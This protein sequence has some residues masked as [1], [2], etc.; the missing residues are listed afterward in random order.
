[1]SLTQIIKQHDFSDVSNVAIPYNILSESYGHDLAVK[2]LQLEHEAFELGEKR[3]RLNLE[4]QIANG[5]GADNSAAKPLL[6]SLHE[7][8]SASLTEAISNLTHRNVAFELAPILDIHKTAAITLKTIFSRLVKES[9]NST[10]GTSLIMQVAGMIETE[11]RYGRIRDEEKAYFNKHVNKALKKRSQ[12]SYKVQFMRAV[13]AHMIDSETLTSEWKPWDDRQKMAVGIVALEAAI[14]CGLCERDTTRGK[15]AKVH[16][17]I[18]LTEESL[19][20]VAQRAYSLAGISPVYQPCVVP[21]KQWTG[22]KNGGYW[23]NGRKPT[24]FI[25]AHNAFHLKRYEDV[26]MPDVYKAVNIAQETPFKVHGKVLNVLDALLSWK[27]VP[28]EKF[29]GADK[30]EKPDQPVDI[31]TN[32]ESLKTWKKQMVEYYQKE[33]TRKSRRMKLQYVYAQASKFSQFKALWFP[34]NLDWRGRLYYIP[35]FNPQGNDMTK[36]LLTFARSKPIGEEGFY[37]LKIHGAN[38][39]STLVPELGAKTD[40]I[41]L[42]DRAKWVDDN[43][44]M[45]RAIAKNPLDN[46]E[47]MDADSPFC[48]LAFCFEYEGVMTHGLGYSSSLPIAFDASCSGTQHFSCMLLDRLGGHAVNLTAGAYPRDIYKIVA[49]KV[50]IQLKIDT[51]EGTFEQSVDKKITT[52]GVTETVVVVKMGTRHLAKTW[53][54][55]GVTRSETKR[56]VMTVSY[57]SRKFGFSEQ[58]MEDT[59]RPS[60]EK[61][62]GECFRENSFQYAIYLAGLVWDAVSTTVI[63]AVEAMKWLQ[64]Y[65]KLLAAEIVDK[66]T[67]E[68]IKPALPVHWTTTDGFPVW[69]EYREYEETQV[70]MMFAGTQFRPRMQGAKSFINKRKQESG[71]APNFTHSNDANH[72]R[73][74]VVHS[75]EIYAIVD[76]A[77]VHDSF[78][79]LAADAG[80]LFKAVR[81]TMVNIYSNNDVLAQFSAEVE[82]QLDDSQLEDIPMMPKK[83]TLDLQEILQ[84]PFAF[85]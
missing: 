13:E 34:A 11:L 10:D 8:M 68:I 20:L 61:G 40:K 33:A 30:A 7:S 78:G 12:T 21:P 65:A 75:N 63:A 38:C 27:N 1:M 62:T 39:M 59:I 72:L 41:P 6:E 28:I 31:D 81:E 17:I 56:S 29:P 53:L 5:Q 3:F 57:G 84:S 74:T 37:W 54:A 44:D 24:A 52:K 55:F 43:S 79:T 16:T 76:W 25:R 26:E 45:I 22:T 9:S 19:E 18:S 71:I 23:S 60:I 36:G 83:G 77:L 2:Q 15:G 32:P 70:R 67:G 64:Q 48:F 46:T 35:G 58:I 49:D 47:W 50:N 42:D 4:R 73:V 80:K 14:A 51:E 82:Q 85:S 69:Q 66:K